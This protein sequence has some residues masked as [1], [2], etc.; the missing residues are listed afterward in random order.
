MTLADK[1]LKEFDNDLTVYFQGMKLPVYVL[2][3][4]LLKIT[5]KEGHCVPFILNLQQVEL[6]KEICLQRRQ[7]KPVRMNILKSRQIGYSTFIAGLFFIIG[8]FTPNMKVGV[9]ADVEKHAKDIFSKYEYFYNHLN[10]SNPYKD[11]IEDY[12]HMNRG[13]RHPQTYKPE[14]KAQRGQTMMATKA[15]NSIIEVV[16]AGEGS[17]RSNTYHLL[18]LSESAF[19]KN[20]KITLNGLLETVSSKNKNSFIFLETTA[21]GFN[22]YKDRWDKDCQGKT[23]YKAVFMPWFKNPEYCN[24]EFND[25]G[26]KLP[27]LEE[28]LYQKGEEYHLTNG[29]LAWYWD[30]YQDKG[31]K[32]LVLQEYPFC[33]TDSFLTSGNCIFNTELI[34]KRK[35]ELLK[36]LDNVKK[37]LFVTTA[38]YSLDGRKIDFDLEGFVPSR[39]GAISI[40]KEPIKGHPYIVNCDPAMGGEDYYAIQV[41]DNYTCEQVATYHTKSPSGDD[42]VAFQLIALGK[43]YNNALISAECNNSNG[44]YILQVAQKCGYKFIYKDTEYDTISDRWEDKYGYKTKQNNKN[45]MVTMFKLAFRDNYRMVN[46]YD[47]LCE[48][49]EFEVYRNPNTLK[50]SLRASGN[51]HDDLVM[52][53]CGCFYI[54]SS[55]VQR[56]T[57]TTEENYSD[58]KFDNFVIN[59]FKQVQDKRQH[60]TIKKKAFIRW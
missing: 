59:P 8:M 50:E 45:P 55:E 38:K 20:L 51:S 58:N 17:G 12:E 29:Q 53:M 60:F 4:K 16:V 23:S 32:G 10:D 15:G 13:M 18:H 56:C 47:T 48:M 54:R 6:Y 11:E 36:Q 7:G 52:S 46:D 19:F 33:P 57:P 2:M 27:T 3:E 41:L 30:K 31:D 49:E 5:D 22:E 9:V 24:E 1:E 34:A 39:N 26:F 28:W 35:E 14:L 25:M 42:E 43:Y 44:S 21:N 40:Y 37:G